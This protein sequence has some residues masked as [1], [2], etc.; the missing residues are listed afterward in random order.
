MANKPQDMR[1]PQCGQQWIGTSATCPNPS[2]SGIAKS[3]G[4]V[5]RK[6]FQGDNDLKKGLR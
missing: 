2:C 5:T 6:T 1:C 4:E 3:E